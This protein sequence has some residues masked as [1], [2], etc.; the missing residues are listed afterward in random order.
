MLRSKYLVAIFLCLLAAT[1]LFL[2]QNVHADDDEGGG[3]IS[4]GSV[5]GGGDGDGDSS[6]CGVGYNYAYLLECSGYSWIFYQSTGN[7]T[8]RISFVPYTSSG[9]KVT[10][11]K[12]CSEHAAENG[13]FWHLG[14]NAMGMKAS[15]IT[16]AYFADNSY[17][18]YY[19]GS[20]V[21]GTKYRTTKNSWGH[22]DTYQYGSVPNSTNWAPYKRNGHKV[23]GANITLSNNSLDHRIYLNGTKIYEASKYGTRDQVLA[24]YRKAYSHLHPNATQAQINAATNSWSDM[25]GI[26]A[27]CYWDGMDGNDLY[28]QKRNVYNNANIGSATKEVTGRTGWATATYTGQSG[29]KFIGWKTGIDG[30]DT[31]GTANFLQ[32]TS[33]EGHTTYVSDRYPIGDDYNPEVVFYEKTYDSTPK[34]VFTKVHADL[35]NNDRTV[36]AYYAPVCNLTKNAGTGTTITVNRP[37]GLYAIHKNNLGNNASIYRGDVLNITANASAGYSIGSLKVNNADF[38]SG[39]NY[40]ITNT[41]PAKCSNVT[42]TTTATRNKFSGLAKAEEVGKSSNSKTAGWTNG[43]NAGGTNEANTVEMDCS[44]TANCKARFTFNLKALAGSGKTTYAI[45]RM[46]KDTDDAWKWTTVVNS[47]NR[48][49]SGTPTITSSSTQVEKFETTLLPGQKLCYRLAFQ[50]Y[51]NTGGIVTRYATLCAKGRDVSY[52]GYS[53]VTLKSD[54]SKKADTGWKSTGVVSAESANNAYLAL[55]GSRCNNGCEVTWQHGIRLDQ[56]LSSSTTKW[57]T[58]SRGVATGTYPTTSPQSYTESV[59]TG[60]VKCRT[61]QIGRTA[62]SGNAASDG[63]TYGYRYE[64]QSDGAWK[65]VKKIRRTSTRACVYATGTLGSTIDIKVK[66]SSSATWIDANNDST[67][68]YAK[69]SDIIN[70]KGT[71]TPKVQQASGFTAPIIKLSASGATTITINNSSNLTNQV[72]FNSRISPSWNNAFSIR[73]SGNKGSFTETRKSNTIGSAASYT[74]SSRNYVIT[75]S[76]VGSR[77]TASAITNNLSGST[78]TKTAPK[79]ATFSY[80]IGSGFT[81]DINYSS[82]SDN[83]FIAVPYNFVNTTSIARNSDEPLYAGESA[84]VNL[85]VTTNP[86]HNSATG[87]TYATIVRDAKWKLEINYTDPLTGNAV[88]AETNSKTGNLNAN[89]KLDGDTSTKAVSLNIPDVPAGTNICLRSAVYPANSG[90]DTNWS[91]KSGSGTWAYSSQKCFKVAKRPSIEVWG[92]NSYS[93][94]SINMTDAVKHNLANYTNYQAEDTTKDYVFGSWTELGLVAGGTVKGFSSGASLGFSTNTNGDLWP[95]YQPSDGNGN[96]QNIAGRAPG[97]SD[98]K[99]LCYRSPLTFAN[100][101]SGE[102]VG[103][104]AGATATSSASDDK[105]A[106][107][108]KFI[109]GGDINIADTN[110]VVLNNESNLREGTNTYYYYG[111]SNSLTVPGGLINKGTIQVIHSENNIT[112]NGNLE[113]EDDYTTLEDIPKLIIYT[114]KEIR[115]SCDA[116][117]IDAVLIADSVLTCNNIENDTITDS[118]IKA[119]INDRTNS[120]QLKINGAI[121]TGKLYPNRTY[122]AATG[123][124]SMVPAEIINFDPSLYTWGYSTRIDTGYVNEYTNNLGTVYLKE[125]APRY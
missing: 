80:V 69:P 25:N 42:I 123:A 99:S 104:L 39:N 84:N 11:P 20:G 87:D 43:A 85:S 96:N 83:A 17:A 101:C 82:I 125:L 86:K 59:R 10:I 31:A 89:H 75:P 107:I 36:Y 7:T 64:K 15:G 73:L 27:F 98:K 14:R 66:K 13:G 93:R 12:V 116:T 100:T 44:N 102:L 49:L 79:S 105:S 121:I 41:D 32:R 61:L 50:E 1:S 45:Q 5:S 4:S 112:I 97:G 94:G 65:W 70:L 60:Q 68:I 58:E 62:S 33:A 34:N 37:G 117:R 30:H 51:N 67:Q 92:G 26:F 21:S 76:D 47:S 77:I 9:R 113:Y 57:G 63:Y 108:S 28:V 8:G 74:D 53:R 103:L 124:N 109:F 29:Y 72:V 16:Y 48:I 40:T 120:N 46:Y 54:T 110:N 95:S 91:N 24:D 2:P 122:G 111:G 23:A 106:I 3:W 71:Y 81:S 88:T 90:A 115:I 56:G 18:G 35:S 119:K 78:S 19:G 114:E 118:N 22:L 55:D 52:A 6:R 38:T